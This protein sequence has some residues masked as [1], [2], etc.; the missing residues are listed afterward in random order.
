MCSL[1]FHKSFPAMPN[2]PFVLCVI[3]EIFSLAQLHTYITATVHRLLPLPPLLQQQWQQR[4][5]RG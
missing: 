1:S 3:V 4:Q 2:T 5:W